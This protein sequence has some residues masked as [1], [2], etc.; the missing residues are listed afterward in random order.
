AMAGRLGM[1]VSE[2][3]AYADDMMARK[4]MRRYSG[5]LHHRRAGF[6]ANAMVVWRVPEERSEEV[7]LLMADSPHVTHCY[8]RPTYDDWPYSHYT[9]IHAATEEECEAIAEEIA[10][11]NR[12]IES[13]RKGGKRLQPSSRRWLIESVLFVTPT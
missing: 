11:A 10:A 2:L 4:L 1:S 3:F 9:M 6:S 8:E 12:R 5:V 13:G 7:G